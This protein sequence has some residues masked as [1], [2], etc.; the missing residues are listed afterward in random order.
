VGARVILF[1][2]K[3]SDKGDLFGRGM[4]DVA[5]ALG[6]EG[7]QMNISR[8]GREVDLQ[9][10]H[11]VENRHFVCECK[12]HETARG[13]ADTNKF[14]GVLEAERISRTGKD[15]KTQVEGYFIALSGF[16]GTAIEQEEQLGNQ[17]MHLL[18]PTEIVEQLVAGRII[19]PLEEA[20]LVAG[21]IT[22]SKLK[23][24]TLGF[25]DKG[26]LWLLTF[27]TSDHQEELVVVHADGSIA[28]QQFAS[29]LAGLWK[30]FPAASL[31][32]PVSMDDD[33][34]SSEVVLNRYLE[35]LSTEYGSITLEGLPT[36]DDVSSRRLRLESLFVPVH[37]IPAA[38]GVTDQLELA[39]ESAT[40][41]FAD[42]LEASDEEDSGGA[43]DS[44]IID[45]DDPFEHESLPTTGDMLQKARH[46]AVLAMPGGG[47]STLI[48]RLAV[49]YTRP[50]RLA[51]ADD[52]LPARDW[53]P[54]VIRCRQLG[55]L[56]TESIQA[57]LDEVPI[58]AEMADD[59]EVFRNI[60]KQRLL[61]GQI[62]LLID[63]LDEISNPRERVAFVS[64][65][66]TFISRYPATQLVVTSRESGFRL[67]AGAVA[68]L[69]ARFR[70]AELDNDDIAQLTVAWHRELIG[71]K[72]EVIAEANELARRIVAT[73]RVR[74]LASNP[75]LLTTLLLV[76]RWVGDLPRKRSMLYGKAIEVLLATWNV[77]GHEPLDQDEVLPQLAFVAHRM[78]EAGRQ[79]LPAGLLSEWLTDARTAMPELLG[80]ARTS[81]SSLVERVEERSSLLSVSGYE[82]HDGRLQLAYEFKHL[83]FQEYLTALALASGWFDGAAEGRAVIDVIS[84]HL[85]EAAWKEV[86]PLTAVLSARTSSA[87]LE[88]LI[89]LAEAEIA[90]G[91]QASPLERHA[92]DNLLHCL[93][94]EV[95]VSPEVLR[96]SVAVLCRES[97]SARDEFA[98]LME[99]R[100]SAEV[101]PILIG[102]LKELRPNTFALAGNLLSVFAFE[103]ATLTW[104]AVDRLLV[105]AEPLDRWKGHLYAM[106]ALFAVA[107]THTHVRRRGPI[108]FGDLA[109]ADGCRVLLTRLLDMEPEDEVERFLWLWALA[110]GM[111]TFNPSHDVKAR[112]LNKLLGIWL[113]AADGLLIACSWA[114]W[115]T[116]PEWN[117]DLPSPTVEQQALIDQRKHFV[118]ERAEDV[119]KAAHVFDVLLGGEPGIDKAEGL[120]DAASGLSES[121]LSRLVTLIEGGDT[122]ISLFSRRK[123]REPLLPL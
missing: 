108:D 62:L 80:Y 47:K 30:A 71:N 32:N 33:S 4:R 81:V 78:M 74:R 122:S 60:L 23:N 55:D 46:A 58:R 36:D 82:E 48:K 97:P 14:A 96:R 94:D 90:V 5:Y 44:D 76:K 77:E 18:G 39:D 84:P 65:L 103:Q 89:P 106:E 21:S 115:A 111:T 121:A 64:Q 118:G 119:V 61:N 107:M 49:A 123:V 28:S 95:P 88:R 20:T 37:L 112:H 9:A 8:S 116:C 27:A 110:W 24:A 70:I 43:E 101:L 6:Y 10:R 54:V 79:T 26:W 11:R 35:Y 1:P 31:V 53:L 17:R 99:T 85:Q 87:L 12:A 59:A 93:L 22:S 45:T 113:E 25:H 51:D 67:V 29:G 69:C 102:E 83:T 86:V 7:V 34:A 92:Y 50:E 16:T 73:D 75:L 91:S 63:G 100:F 19:V 114:V 120:R 52:G 98:R 3:P 105:S 109:E 117:L 40:G 41:E 57:I 72:P 2:S 42:E 104:P 56:V 68:D 38:D 66:R 13:G 15:S